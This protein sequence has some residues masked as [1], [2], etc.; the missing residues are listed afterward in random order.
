MYTWGNTMFVI[1]NKTSKTLVLLIDGNSHFLYPK[2]DS[3][4]R[5]NVSVNELTSQIRNMKKLRFIQIS[6]VD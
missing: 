4:K 6:K 1:K 2:G 3:K 5:D